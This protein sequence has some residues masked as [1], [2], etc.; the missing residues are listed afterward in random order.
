MLIARRAIGISANRRKFA[1]VGLGMTPA[2]TSVGAP[3]ASMEGRGTVLRAVSLP[4][5]AW[6]SNS[7]APFKRPLF[8]RL[9][10]K[11]VSGNRPTT[12]DNF[13]AMRRPTSRQP[14]PMFMKSLFQ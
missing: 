4:A 11:V 7:D 3:G 14:F 5:A 13:S 9:G 1:G 8:G 2:R 10:G 12:T 6:M